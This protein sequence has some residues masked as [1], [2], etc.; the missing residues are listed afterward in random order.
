M[1]LC[2]LSSAVNAA[3]EKSSEPRDEETMRLQGRFERS[4]SNP[5]GTVFRVV[6]E[7]EGNR[8]VVT[9]YDD[10][11]NV[12]EAHTS[13]FKVDRRGPVRVLS[14]YNL[15][16]T[17]GPSKGHQVPATQ[18]YIYRFDGKVFTE[19][20][21]LLEGDDGPPRMMHWRYIAPREP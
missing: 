17:A 21:G 6:K 14:F 8:S 3:A 7:V 20:W 11:G 10:I 2:L 13:E 4:F 16:V 18:S 9:T 5:A 1:L 19:V 15:L 12:V